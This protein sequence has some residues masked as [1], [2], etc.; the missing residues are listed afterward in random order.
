LIARAGSPDTGSR[1]FR[2]IIHCG[3]LDLAKIGLRLNWG[4]INALIWLLIIDP[5]YIA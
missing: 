2:L 3:R 5:A 1:V 4:K